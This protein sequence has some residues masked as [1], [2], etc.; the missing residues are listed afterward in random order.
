MIMK[1]YIKTPILHIV[2]ELTED[3]SNV[4]ASTN[5]VEMKHPSVKRRYKQ[6]DE[7]LKHVN[8]LARSIIGSM[9]GRHFKINRVWTS[10]KSYTYYI[11]FQ[12]ADKNG[13]LWRQEL[14]LQIE[15]R[16]HTSSTHLDIG[17][18]NSDLLVRAFYLEGK[19]YRDM[20]ALM[21]TI[22]KI[23]DDLQKGDFSSFLQLQ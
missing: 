15:L 8:D 14:E 1:R 22:W 5:F 21:Q 7:W 20:Y 2:V 4:A 17:E 12:P 9:Q 13:D 6:S 10:K 23:L 3:N 19:S 11:R 18:V 16:D